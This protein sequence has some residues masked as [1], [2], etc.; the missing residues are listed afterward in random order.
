MRAS[1][2]HLLLTLLAAGA[3][4]AKTPSAP[5]ADPAEFLRQV[6]AAPALSAAGRRVEAARARVDAAGRLP[7]PEIEAM[8]SRMRGPMNGRA[9]MWELNLRQ[10]LPRRGERAADR[11]RAQAAV[12]MSQADV[13]LMLGEMAADVA[14]ALAEADGA[15]AR[16]AL[17]ETQLARLDS[18]LRTLEVQL[19][20]GSGGR[21]ADRLTV[22]SR[23]ASLQLMV[24]EARRMAAD[25]EAEARGRLGLG[26]DAP[27]PGYAAP[28]T[29]EVDANRAAEMQLVAARTDEANAMLKMARASARP[30]TAVGL[31]LE[32]ERN[33]MGDED[34]VGLAFM[35]E[36]PWRARRY[37]RAESRAAEA[38][39]AAA[40]WDGAAVRYRIASAVTRVERAERLADTARQLSRETLERLN[41]ELDALVRGA[42][43]AGMGESTIFQTV[44]I[45]EKAT[46]AELQ[47]IDAQTAAQ[48][49]RA[50]L[51]RYTAAP[52]LPE[53]SPSNSS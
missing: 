42:S 8:G 9:T 44:E 32:R 10:P 43:V 13:A 45:L 37:A 30:M 39:R 7:D 2:P 31:R 24:E 47:V 33:A 18:V 40:Q 48:T 19:S 20:T 15:H 34:T 27:L 4:S 26:P 23:V 1:L 25:A 12:A 52:P 49:A 35:S 11:E 53:F 21:L 29:A 6:A 50:E 16:I 3:V 46:D 51:W 14:M 41:A 38:E 36:I 28:T 17:L 22:Q 5:T